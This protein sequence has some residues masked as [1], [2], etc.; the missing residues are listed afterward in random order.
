MGR[1][2][3][4]I[5]PLAKL[6]IYGKSDVFLGAQFECAPD[7]CLGPGLKSNLAQFKGVFGPTTAEVVNCANPPN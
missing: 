2:F 4:Q 5:E 6:S 7:F 3:R 1:I